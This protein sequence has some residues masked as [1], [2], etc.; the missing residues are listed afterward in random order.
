MV[1]L[2]KHDGIPLR[3]ISFSHLLISVHT[4]DIR[5][6]YRNIYPDL[7]AE[8][9]ESVTGYD[10]QG[11]SDQMLA[12]WSTTYHSQG[13]PLPEKV[14]RSQ[15]DSN[16]TSRARKFTSHSRCLHLSLHKATLLYQSALAAVA[17]LLGMMNPMTRNRLQGPLWN[18]SNS[19]RSMRS[20]W[21]LPLLRPPTLV[22]PPT[23]LTTPSDSKTPL[24]SPKRSSTWTRC[25]HLTLSFL[26]SEEQC[27]R[28]IHCQRWQS[29]PI[30][31]M[32]SGGALSLAS[33][34]TFG[35]QPLFVHYELC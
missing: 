2:S 3:L 4:G 26:V 31:T 9:N 28:W 16:T 25:W 19:R 15:S 21:R 27:I 23:A 5:V 35:K 10:A 8:M 11:D 30:S 1:E 20:Q 34:T 13:Q 6:H 29:C 17:S 33:S 32:L 22:V 12:T 18:Y 24:L 7:T 14:N